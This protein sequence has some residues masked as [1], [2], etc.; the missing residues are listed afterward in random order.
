MTARLIITFIFL[1]I[2]GGA[3]SYLGNQLGRYIGR[4]KMSIFN[5]RPRHTSILITVITGSLIAVMTL[6]FAYVSSWEVRTLFKG[7]ENFRQTISEVTAKTMEQK[8]MGGVLYRPGEPFFA[9][10]IDGDKSPEDIESQLMAVIAAANGT[11]LQ[12]SKEV[13]EIMGAEFK[14]PPDG[15]VLGYHKNEIENLVNTIHKIR[16]RVIVEPIADNYAFL[17]EKFSVS[18]KIFEYIPKVFDENDIIISGIIDGRQGEVEIAKDV[19]KLLIEAKI[20]AIRKGM[21]ENPI[22]YELVTIDRTKLKSAIEKIVSSKKQCIINVRAVKA[23]DNKT[24]LDVYLE[25]QI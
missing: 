5:L 1:A 16:G 10:V 22:T 8:Q 14:M 12:R 24:P 7:L 21:L 20:I 11:A 15:K 9:T 3:V 6:T 4:R 19:S 18:L 25:V 2:I 17:G 13:A 23:T